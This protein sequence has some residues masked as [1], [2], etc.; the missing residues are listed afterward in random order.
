[1]AIALVAGI[2]IGYVDSRP[3]W[4]DTGITA[5]SL[6]LA[7]GVAAFV[8]GRRPWLVALAAGIWVPL[9][10]LPYLASGGPLT[11]LVFAGIGAA[12]GWLI[13]RA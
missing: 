13:R 5:I 1:M 9:F 6:L 4:D 11:A 2:A 12:I 10:E 8:V 7:G 3:G